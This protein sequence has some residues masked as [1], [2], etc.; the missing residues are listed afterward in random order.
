[1]ELL[2]LQNETYLNFKAGTKQ[3]QPSA[4]CST[5][6]SGNLCLGSDTG[7][8]TDSTLMTVCGENTA[9]DL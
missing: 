3:P 2:D 9:E 1:M 5:T 4:A 7:L 6:G 8:R